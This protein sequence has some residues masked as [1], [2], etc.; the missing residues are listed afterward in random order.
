MK[1]KISFDITRSPGSFR[2][3]EADIHFLCCIL[4]EGA[5]RKPD[6]RKAPR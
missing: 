6:R 4:N 2:N 1:P 5:T 3:F